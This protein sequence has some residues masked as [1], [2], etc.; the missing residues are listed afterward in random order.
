VLTSSDQSLEDKSPEEV[1]G[2]PA[3]V[4]GGNDGKY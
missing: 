2:T 1:D 4:A 3:G